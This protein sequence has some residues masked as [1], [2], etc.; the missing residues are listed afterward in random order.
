MYIVFVRFEGETVGIG[1]RVEKL[2]LRGIYFDNPETLIDIIGAAVKLLDLHFHECNMLNLTLEF[3]L[4][5]IEILTLTRND[6]TL[7]LRL[8]VKYEVEG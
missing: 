7:L 6:G 4:R 1:Y 5:I 8:I 2:Y 3:V